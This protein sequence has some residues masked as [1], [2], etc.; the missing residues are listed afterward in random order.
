MGQ[1]SELSLLPMVSQDYNQ[2]VSQG[3]NLV[4]GLAR[5]GSASVLTQV[6]GRIQFLMVVGLRASVSCWLPVRVHPQLLEM[7]QFL[8]VWPPNIGS[9]P[10]GSLL[11]QNQWRGTERLSK[12]SATL[13]CNIPMS[14]LTWH[15]L[16]YPPH[17]LCCILPVRS[18]SQHHCSHLPTTQMEGI[19][20]NHDISRWDG[21][22]PPQ[23]PVCHRNWEEPCEG[24]SLWG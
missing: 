1:G 17:H 15:H 14:S 2:G 24:F 19:T 8:G 16:S 13:S 20:E 6:I 22:R 7:P 9:L 10:H 11:L 23:E 12:T 3:Q 21:E 4:W 5:K 18:K